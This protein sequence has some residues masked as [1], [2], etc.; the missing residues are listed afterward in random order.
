[1]YYLFLPKFLFTVDGWSY[2]KTVSYLAEK[3]TASRTNTEIS[4]LRV[5]LFPPSPVIRQKWG[6]HVNQAQTPPSS[7]ECVY[8]KGEGTDERK[9]GSPSFW[10]DF[11]FPKCDSTQPW[12]TQGVSMSLVLPL[13]LCFP[14]HVVIQR[15]TDQRILPA[16][17]ISFPNALHSGDTR[18]RY[19]WSFGAPRGPRSRAGAGAQRALPRHSR[20]LAPTGSSSP[21]PGS[22]CPEELLFLAFLREAIPTLHRSRTNATLFVLFSSTNRWLWAELKWDS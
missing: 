19:I 17:Q 10:E 13:P 9:H 18:H 16:L 6:H 1:M 8:G 22:P 11:S 15:K 7:Q 14:A 2:S 20:A 12:C 21:G 3:W 4:E 5:C